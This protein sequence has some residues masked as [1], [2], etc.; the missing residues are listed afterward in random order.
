MDRQ[1]WKFTADRCWET[2]AKHSPGSVSKFHR[3]LL[4]PQQ[5]SAQAR[6]HTQSHIVS[7]A[8]TFL[9]FCVA[10]FNFTHLLYL[11]LCV[12]RPLSGSFVKWHSVVHEFFV[13]NGD[14][15]CVNEW[16]QPVQCLSVP[17]SWIPLN[18]LET[19]RK[20]HLSLWLLCLLSAAKQKPSLP[21]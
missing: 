15:I 17:A 3:R 9:H 1:D 2:D 11:T 7:M 14:Y 18:Y 5:P 4:Y 12:I 6:M 16:I 19:E 8:S 20:L 21:M 10:D 13:Y